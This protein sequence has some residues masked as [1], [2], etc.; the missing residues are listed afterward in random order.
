MKELEIVK[1]WQMAKTANNGEKVELLPTKMR[2]TFMDDI[3]NDI[4]RHQSDFLMLAPV[5]Y[6]L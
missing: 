6:L 3:L 1:F 5:W 4:V 2:K